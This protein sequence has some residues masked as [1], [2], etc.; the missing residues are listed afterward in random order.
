MVVFPR[1]NRAEGNKL[2]TSAPV[3]DGAATGSHWFLFSRRLLLCYNGVR[4][5]VSP[6]PGQ[7]SRGSQ[8]SSVV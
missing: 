7:Q 5:V 3:R 6:G 2:H 4:M 8:P 1:K